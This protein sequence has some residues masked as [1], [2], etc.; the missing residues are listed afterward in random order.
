[1]STPDIS[2]TDD[3]I[4]LGQFL[5]LASLAESGAQARELLEA[6]EVSV[7]GEQEVRRGRQL[8]H[9]DVVE[10]DLPH[11]RHTARVV[12]SKTSQL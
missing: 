8:H 5:K 7:N 6:G 9:G 2:I 11:G 3:M 10:V 12:T 4:R 1:M